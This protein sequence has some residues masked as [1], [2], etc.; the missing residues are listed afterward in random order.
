MWLEM[1]NSSLASPTPSTPGSCAVSRARSGLPTVTMI[2]VRRRA[3]EGA[4]EAAPSSAA[5]RVF[6]K[7]RAPSYTIPTSLR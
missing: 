4:E 6:V 1:R 3:P 2:F 7:G 5:T